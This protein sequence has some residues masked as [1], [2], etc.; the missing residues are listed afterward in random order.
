MLKTISRKNNLSAIFI[1]S[2]HNNILAKEFYLIK[3]W[4]VNSSIAYFIYNIIILYKDYVFF[5]EIKFLY[6]LYITRKLL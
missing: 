4:Y 5:L 3:I 2:L 1:Y 6:I